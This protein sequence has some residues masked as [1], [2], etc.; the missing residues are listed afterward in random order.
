MN[1]I[2]DF[3]EVMDLVIA[4]KLKPMLDK[5][6]PIKEASAAQDRLWRGENFGKIM[7]DI[8]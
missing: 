2:A 5:K 4:G 7:L 1:P 8:S 6:F 3:V